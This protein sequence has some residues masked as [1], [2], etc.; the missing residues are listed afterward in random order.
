MLRLTLR[1]PPA[2]VSYHDGIASR[3]GKVL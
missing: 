3:N 1:H 2:E